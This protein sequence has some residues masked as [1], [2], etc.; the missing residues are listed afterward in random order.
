MLAVI[1][2]GYSLPW[3]SKLLFSVES[4]YCR[5]SQLNKTLRLSGYGF[6]AISGTSASTPSPCQGPEKTKE[7][8]KER[9][10]A[11]LSVHAF[12]TRHGCCIH[13]PLKSVAICRKPTHTER[14]TNLSQVGEG[15]ERL[16][17]ELRS[18]WPLIAVWGR[19]S[20]FSLLG[21]WTLVSCPYSNVWPMY[22]IAALIILSVL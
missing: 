20:H 8:G 2:W 1:D 22:T 10:E 15:L 17:P 16:H 7:E 18:Y 5:N 4:N 13:K 6:S 14:V 19:E 11:V 21:S 9:W 12:W 3:S